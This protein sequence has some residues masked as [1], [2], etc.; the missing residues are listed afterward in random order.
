VIVPQKWF[1]RTWAFTLPAAQLPN[2]VERLRAAPERLDERTRGVP[3]AL[4]TRRDGDAWSIQEQAGHLLDLEPLWLRRAEQLL[5]GEAALAAADLTNRKTHEAAHN[6][7]ALAGII[8]EFRAARGLLVRLLEAADEAD[9]ER[10]AL[11]PRLGTPMRLVDLALFTAEHDDHHL[12]AITA[13]R[14]RWGVA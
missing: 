7:R 2:I 12:A 6:A 4:L 3:G 8:E 5:A 13:L 14:R 11:H 9:A 1:E 10:S